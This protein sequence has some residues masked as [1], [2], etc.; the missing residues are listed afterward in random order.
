MIWDCPW[1]HLT[2][3]PSYIIITIE[4]A[5]T[6]LFFFMNGTYILYSTPVV[7]A[8]QLTAAPLACPGENFTFRCN[9][10]GN[11]SSFTIWRVNGNSECPLPHRSNSSSIC[12]PNNAFRAK[13]GTGFA[14]SAISYSSTLSGTTNFTLNGTLVECFGPANSV[15]AGN[16]VGRNTL[17]ISGQY[18]EV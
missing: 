13:P 6:D 8:G 16:M 9:V 10:T 11:M 1:Q 12:G 18:H 17:Q 15:D 14:T 2:T 4:R 7:V 5:F 3:L